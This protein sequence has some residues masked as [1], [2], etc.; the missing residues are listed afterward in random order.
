MET[1]SHIATAATPLVLVVGLY[2]LLRQV[3]TLQDGLERLLA[4]QFTENGQRQLAALRG[5]ATAVEQAFETA[6]AV[7][8]QHGQVQIEMLEL[9]REVEAT[10][11]ARIA[12]LLE[13]RGVGRQMLRERMAERVRQGRPV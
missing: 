11:T 12:A 9:M 13:T 8:N 6:M 5:I 3:R 1:A 2:L 10:K 4:Q 7:S